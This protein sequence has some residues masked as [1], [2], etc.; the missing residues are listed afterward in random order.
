MSKLEDQDLNDISENENEFTNKHKIS[1]DSKLSFSQMSEISP[2]KQI[3]KVYTVV[4]N[5][6]I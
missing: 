2:A 3:I 6:L 1:K 4:R 5:K